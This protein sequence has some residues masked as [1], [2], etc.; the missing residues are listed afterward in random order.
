MKK[1]GICTASPLLTGFGTPERRRWPACYNHLTGEERIAYL[2]V[3]RARE[4]TNAAWFAAAR[5]AC[6]AWPVTDGF[7]SWTPA[8]DVG[9]ADHQYTRQTADDLLRLCEDDEARASFYLAH[10]QD[11]RCAICA[12]RAELVEDHDHATGL[13]RGLLCRSCNTREGVDRGTVGPFARYRTRNPASIL[14]VRIRYWDPV[15]GAYAEPVPDCAQSRAE[16]PWLKVQAK[17]RGGQG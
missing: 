9:P 7:A 5:P 10:W 15:M 1:G 4:A 13:V 8:F 12:T 2:D 16:N 17:K 11:D 3:K 14:G 6:W